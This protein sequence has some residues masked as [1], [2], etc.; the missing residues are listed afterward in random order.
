VF[1]MKK[2]LTAEKGWHNS[3]GIELD[4]STVYTGTQPDFPIVHRCNNSVCG[5]YE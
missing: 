4:P 1:L 2:I 5:F 3:V